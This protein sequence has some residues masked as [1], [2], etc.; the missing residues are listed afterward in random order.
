MLMRDFGGWAMARQVLLLGMKDREGY[1]SFWNDCISSG[2][3]GC[4]LIELGLRSKVELEDTGMR[5]RSLGS[6]KVVANPSEKAER[7]CGASAAAH[8]HAFLHP[9][10]A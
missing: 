9:R 2:L 7:P 6:R 1:L 5:K 8:P 10:P 3:R 4:M